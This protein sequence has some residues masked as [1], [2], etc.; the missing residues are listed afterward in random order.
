ME[1]FH[2]YITYGQ[3]QAVYWSKSKILHI[4][5]ENRKH[6]DYTTEI[7]KNSK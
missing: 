3:E 5:G 4:V 6:V 1:K 2:I 7:S